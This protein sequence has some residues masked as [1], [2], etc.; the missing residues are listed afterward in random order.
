M[1]Y[2]RGPRDLTH[3]H[4]PTLAPLL[5]PSIPTGVPDT[6]PSHRSES[7]LSNSEIP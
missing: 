1:Q 3:I 6:C 5:L 7:S 4:L 2:G